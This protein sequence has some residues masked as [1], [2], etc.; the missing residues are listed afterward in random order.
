MAEFGVNV[1]VFAELALLDFDRLD[2]LRGTEREPGTRSGT[3]V[4]VGTLIGL[5]SFPVVL[6]GAAEDAAAL[7]DV[8][9]GSARAVRTRSTSQRRSAAGDA[10]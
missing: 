7:S 4:A 8:L 6:R 5:F 2:R 1:G 3:A 10:W 9:A